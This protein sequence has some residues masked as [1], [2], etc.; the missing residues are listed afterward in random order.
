MC[1]SACG[2]E[3]DREGRDREREI[4]KERSGRENEGEKVSLCMCKW[5]E[6]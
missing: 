6:A 5:A 2:I 4:K 3:K 1:V